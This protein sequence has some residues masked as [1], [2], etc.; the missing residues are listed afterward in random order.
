MKGKLKILGIV[1][2]TMICSCSKG[3]DCNTKGDFYSKI[4]VE[5]SNHV[6]SLS[7]VPF[8]IQSDTMFAKI[9]STQIVSYDLCSGNFQEL[10]D[11]KSINTDSLAELFFSDLTGILK[12]SS[13][14]PTSPLSL[15]STD[16]IPTKHGFS[17]IV[18]LTIPSQ[19]IF[20]GTQAT[21]RNRYPL[22]LQ[23]HDK[24]W[25]VKSFDYQTEWD[26]NQ[27]FT[28]FDYSGGM[29][30]NEDNIIMNGFSLNKTVPKLCC[31]SYDEEANRF[32]LRDSLVLAGLPSKFPSQTSSGIDRMI[33]YAHGLVLTRQQKIYAYRLE[34]MKIDWELNIGG[35]V[36]DLVW[37][38]SSKL[39]Y[40]LSEDSYPGNQRI[41]ILNQIDAETGITRKI[42][43]VFKAQEVLGARIFDERIHFISIEGENA[44]YT[45]KSI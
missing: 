21:L 32:L 41:I 33:N 34:D 10:I 36:H 18:L 39:I 7:R 8:I 24:E 1:Y 14:E 45:S 20:R 6:L 23:F 29:L 3:L 26:S 12:P 9:S 5:D 44:V 28:W 30:Y 31:M 40:A 27:T 25:I 22:M 2:V 13:I 17:S 42:D 19:I 37:S 4:L 16:L 43:T 35:Y 15:I 38:V 11:L